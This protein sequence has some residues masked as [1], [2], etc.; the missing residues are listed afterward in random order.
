[1]KYSRYS[2]S[3]YW[4]KNHSK[5][6]FSFFLLRTEVFVLKNQPTKSGLACQG[7]S[8]ANST[9]TPNLNLSFTTRQ[10]FCWP[11]RQAQPAFL[12]FLEE[13]VIGPIHTGTR[14]GWIR[15]CGPSRHEESCC[16]RSTASY[17]WTSK[18]NVYF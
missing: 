15:N 12:I 4:R 7:F 18:V 2:Y 1:M 10:H 8:A 14:H 9:T 16:E 17:S 13:S 3:E 6:A 5:Y 11:E